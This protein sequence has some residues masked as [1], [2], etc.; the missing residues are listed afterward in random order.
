MAVFLAIGLMPTMVLA[1]SPIYL[2]LGDSITTGY[3]LN[4][5]EQSFAQQVA[6]KGFELDSSYATDGETS[7]MLLSKLQNGSI[8][9]SNAELI[10]I[11]IGGQ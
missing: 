11:T 2:A 6:E 8:D 5:G 9:V 7:G 10:T 4:P 3:R 1:Q